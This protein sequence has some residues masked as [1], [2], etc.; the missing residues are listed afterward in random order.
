MM[1]ALA[2]LRWGPFHQREQ[3]LSIFQTPDVQIFETKIAV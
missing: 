2:V 3:S 1:R